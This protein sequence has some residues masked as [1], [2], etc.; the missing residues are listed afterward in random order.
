MT[1]KR[2]EN[3]ILQAMGS[4]EKLWK[5]RGGIRIRTLQPCTWDGLEREDKAERHVTSP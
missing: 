1:R 5:E 4:Q 2:I 3:F